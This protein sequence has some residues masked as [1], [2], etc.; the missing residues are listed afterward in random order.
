MAC[1]S[2]MMAVWAWLWSH[3]V[4]KIHI[5]LLLAK[6]FIGALEQLDVVPDPA[7]AIHR[8]FG[9]FLYVM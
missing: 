1:M 8:Y 3:Y 7:L 2:A 6:G 9:R 5:Y 4:V